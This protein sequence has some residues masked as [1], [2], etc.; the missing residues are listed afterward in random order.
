MSRLSQENNGVVI[1]VVLVLIAVIVIWKFQES[2][3]QAYER[4]YE[5]ARS[6][7]LDTLYNR[8]FNDSLGWG[9]LDSTKDWYGWEVSEKLARTWLDRAADTSHRV[10]EKAA[11]AW[12]MSVLLRDRKFV[13]YFDSTDTM[14]VMEMEG[15]EVKHGKD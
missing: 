9:S 3:Q 15:V 10:Y 6:V 5:D 13:I 8:W 14:P 12:A 11:L 7:L 2:P 1:V 4:G